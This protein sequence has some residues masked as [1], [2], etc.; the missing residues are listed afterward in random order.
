M[1]GYVRVSIQNLSKYF[2][3]VYFLTIN[4][5]RVYS[6]TVR[7]ILPP[8]NKKKPKLFKTQNCF[9]AKNTSFLHSSTSLFQYNASSLT[10]LYC[11]YKPAN[12]ERKPV[13]N[14]KLAHCIQWSIKSCADIYLHIAKCINYLGRG[15]LSSSK[16]YNKTCIQSNLDTSVKQISRNYYW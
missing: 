6:G 12:H 16:I 14:V 9:K 5:L 4:F 10:I 15:L 8:A 1:G 13:H 7:T 11:E 2:L 3:P